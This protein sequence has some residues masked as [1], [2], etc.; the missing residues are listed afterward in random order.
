MSRPPACR[1]CAN[2]GNLTGYTGNLSKSC[3]IVSV[4]REILVDWTTPAGSG[5]VSVNFF[6]L[7]TA[8]ATQRTALSVFLSGLQGVL[9]T[10]VSYEIRNAGRE[11]NDNTGVLTGAWSDSAVHADSGSVSGEPVPDASQMLYRWFTDVIIGGRFLQGRTF[12][13]GLTDGNMVDGNLSAGAIPGL[14]AL[15]DAFIATGT[16]FGVWHRPTSGVGG[17]FEPATSCGVW[18]EL[19]VLRRRR[20]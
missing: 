14:V 19:A 6:D 4:P 12:I 17:Q 15:G 16:G 18:S 7:G 20:Q 5:F 9:D 1:F 8:V 11:L 2:C 13:P 3:Y 10:G